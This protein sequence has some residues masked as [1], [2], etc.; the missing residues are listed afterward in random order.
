MS[1]WRQDL[2]TRLTGDAPLAAVFGQRI[3]FFE[4]A[5]S[6]DRYP[7]LVL[8]EISPGREYTHD[9]PDGLDR[10]RVQFDIY[11]DT[12]AALLDGETALLIAMEREQTVGGTKFH[13][14]F[15]DARSMPDP[16]DLANQRRILRLSMD[17][18]FFHESV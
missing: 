11:S 8:Q 17:F 1:A 10:P 13:F 18:S 16:G 2:I 14:G 6:W 4:A 5:R 3:A 9:G 12:G 15:L 7:Q